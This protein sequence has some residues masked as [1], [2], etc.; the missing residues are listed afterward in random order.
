HGLEE[1]VIGK[2]R[3]VYEREPTREEQAVALREGDLGSEERVLGRG[4]AGPRARGAA[5]RA[6]PKMRTSGVKPEALSFEGGR[7]Q[8]D[9]S[10]TERREECLVERGMA[11]RVKPRDRGDERVGLGAVLAKDGQK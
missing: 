11:P 4:H 8:G 5:R 10:R 7:G 9:A 6:V 2:P 1:D 3:M